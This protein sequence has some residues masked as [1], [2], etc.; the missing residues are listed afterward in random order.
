MSDD[1]SVAGDTKATA[2]K[3][4]MSKLYVWYIKKTC[5]KLNLQFWNDG[6]HECIYTVHLLYNNKECTQGITF[7]SNDL[8]NELNTFRQVN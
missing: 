6:L 4:E 8:Y 2:C 5:D 1:V 3:Y 7:L